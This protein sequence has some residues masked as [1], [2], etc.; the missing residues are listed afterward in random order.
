MPLH[1]NRQALTDKTVLLLLAIG[2]GA[3]EYF[4]PRIPLLPWL[5]PG[6][7]NIV[8]MVWIIRYGTR[9]AVVFAFL[10]SWITGMFFGFSFLTLALSLSG[11]ALACIAMGAAW[12]LLG[13]RGALGTV[14]LGI[15]GALFHNL[16][17]LTAVFVLLTGNHQ[18]FYQLP[19][20][21]VASIAFGS[22]AG[23]FVPALLKATQDLTNASL[24]D[25]FPSQNSSSAKT[26]SI[27][28]TFLFGF[29]VALMIIDSH[30]VLIAAA[31]GISAWVQIVRKSPV[32]LI[33]P[34]T[35]FWMLFAF[36]GA[37]HLFFTYGTRLPWL[38]GATYEGLSR[39][40]TQWL[41]IWCWIQ[42]GFLLTRY[43]FHALVLSSLSVW[44]RRPHITLAAGVSAAEYFPRVVARIQGKISTLLGLL[45]SRPSSLIETVL[46]DIVAI[47]GENTRS[48]DG[49]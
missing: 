28:N 7:A 10:R 30:P 48:S 26:Y 33:R 42:A 17:Q 29:S 43:R 11:A 1:D 23:L 14:G 3:V 22:F 37:M 34:L 9:D 8:T 39:T 16:G 24:I 45:L 20:M 32:L 35:R 49:T 38:P 19:V 36:V 40:I 18:I 27:V 41:R 2:I 15:T 44:F 47:I 21:I 4:I 5:K 25:N 12:R 31:V 13:R 46:T 6:L